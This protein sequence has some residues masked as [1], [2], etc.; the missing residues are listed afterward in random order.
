MQVGFERIHTFWIIRVGINTWA[1]TTATMQDFLTTKDVTPQHMI[2]MAQGTPFWLLQAWHQ[3]EP[4]GVFWLK[5]LE[6]EMD[7]KGI[8]KPKTWYFSTSGELLKVRRIRGWEGLAFALS[9][10]LILEI[11]S[12]RQVFAWRLLLRRFSMFFTRLPSSIF[13]TDTQAGYVWDLLSQESCSIQPQS[14]GDEDPS[15]VPTSASLWS[16][17]FSFAAGRKSPSHCHQLR[18]WLLYQILKTKSWTSLEGGCKWSTFLW[19]RAFGPRMAS[20]QFQSAFAEERWR[21]GNIALFFC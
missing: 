18:P 3:L 6:A 15:S 14:H 12:S 9:S 1:T 8:Q 13:R 19:E 4:S 20:C 5:D 2:R 10:E 17:D 11:P 16:Q 21:P 7:G